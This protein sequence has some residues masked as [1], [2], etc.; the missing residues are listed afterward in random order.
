MFTVKSCYELISAE[1][2]V[3]VVVDEAILKALNIVLKIEAPAKLLCFGWRVIL[4]RITTKDKLIKH[5]IVLDPNDNLC[6]FCQLHN[7]TISH[8]FGSCTFMENIW[9]LV[10][11]WIG[12]NMN[13][14]ME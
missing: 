9:N 4:N 14:S 6:V 5:S 10:I 2:N 3:G 11:K 8:L 13:L 12:N 7:E 1:V